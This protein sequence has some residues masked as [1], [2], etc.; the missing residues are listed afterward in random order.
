MPTRS[1]APGEVGCLPVSPGPDPVGGQRTDGTSGSEGRC[2]ASGCWALPGPLCCGSW[3][4]RPALLGPWP[5]GKCRCLLGL[6][7]P[8]YRRHRLRQLLGARWCPRT[9]W[10]C[11]ALAAVPCPQHRGFDG[12]ELVLTVGVPAVSP[13]QHPCV[14]LPSHGWPQLLTGSQAGLGTWLG[15][16]LSSAFQGGC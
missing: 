6:C 11:R 1:L 16:V 3:S 8:P 13:P 2:S 7:S 12:T 14:P 10:M 15:S 5:G 4:P 9:W